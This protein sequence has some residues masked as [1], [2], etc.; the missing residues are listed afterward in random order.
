MEVLQIATAW[1]IKKCD[2]QL[3]QI[4]FYTIYHCS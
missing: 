2:G 1:F 4:P 3:L